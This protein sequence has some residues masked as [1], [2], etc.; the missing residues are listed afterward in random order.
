VEADSDLVSS[1]ALAEACARNI[2][3][4]IDEA[5]VGGGVLGLRGWALVTVGLPSD[6]RFQVNGVPFTRVR[7]P[8]ADPALGA[9]LYGVANASSARFT[10]EIDLADVPDSPYFRFEFVQGGDVAKARR[11]AWWYPSRSQSDT[12][13]V[14]RISRVVGSS[15]AFSF[16]LGGATLFHRIQDYLLS[17][18]QLRYEDMGAILDWGCGAG[19]LLSQFAEVKGPEVWGGDVDHDNL[20]Y[21]HGRFPFARCRVF[22]LLPPTEIADATFDLILGISVCSHLSEEHQLRWL[23]ELRRIARPGGLVLLSVQGRSQTALYRESPELMRRVER[24]GFVVK[25][26]NPRINDMLG[27]RSYY[28]DVIQTRT[29]IREHWGREFEV[30][31]FIDGMAANQDLVVMRAP[32]AA[33]AAVSTPSRS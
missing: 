17:R 12:L 19:R 4:L 30:L 25:G 15:D 2:C 9:H 29:H 18:F 3:W 26:V 6:V 5:V 28:L 16:E 14:E 23:A 11:T 1:R 27:A 33:H 24:T 10:C 8:I 32:A 20:T 22:P 21:C 7:F 31:E 13:S